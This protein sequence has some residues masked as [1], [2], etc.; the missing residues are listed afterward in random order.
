VFYVGLSPS[1]RATDRV[2]RAVP[3]AQVEEADVELATAFRPYLFF[4]AAE[5]R[6][7]LD[8]EYAIDQ[9]RVRVC[10]AG[11]R[12]DDCPAVES[13]AEIDDNAIYLEVVDALP[14]RRGGDNSSAYYFRVSRDGQTPYVDYWW[15]Y[16]RNPSPVAGDV[17]CGPGFHLPPYTCH[18]HAGDWEGLTVVLESC[19]SESE[20]CVHVGDQLLHPVTVR[21]A[22]HEHVRPYAWGELETRWSQLTRPSSAAL[23]PVWENFVLPAAADH[24]P[25]PLV[26]V[27]RNSHASYPYPCFGGCSQV[28]RS[29]PEGRHDGGLP[30]THNPSCAGCVKRLPLTRS[31]EP[32]LWN[33]FSGRWGAQECIFGGAYCDFSQAPKSPS[34]QTRYDNP[35]GAD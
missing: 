10:Q 25:R 17:F 31:G 19:S 11:V 12:G 28:G 2:P 9:R 8:I 27:A 13:A 4:D 6:Y 32:A 33:A 20:T 7:P 26:F 30:W 35:G 16:A 21:Y 29:L 18:E 22:Q 14:P 3:P 34:E 15:F 23:G 24:G 1:V 5:T